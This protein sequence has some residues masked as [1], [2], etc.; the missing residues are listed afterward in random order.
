MSVQAIHFLDSDNGIAATDS[1]AIL[2]TTDA[3]ENWSPVSPRGPSGGL[4]TLF[5]LD[6]RRGWAAA[7][8]K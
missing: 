5:F 2:S 4:S 8:A 7:L 3:G 6:E 1:G